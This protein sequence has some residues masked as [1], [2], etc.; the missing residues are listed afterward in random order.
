MAVCCYVVD[1]VM[2]NVTYNS[3]MLSVVMLIVVEPYKD[4]E[5][6]SKNSAMTLST[7][8]LNINDTGHSCNQKNH[9]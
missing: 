3:S 8:T 9:H 1:V 7:T 5:M 2:L 4:T 6:V